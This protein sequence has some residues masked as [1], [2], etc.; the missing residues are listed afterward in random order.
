M[1]IYKILSILLFVLI[2]LD[3]TVSFIYIFSSEKI[4]KQTDC[5]DRFSNKIEGLTCTKE[6]LNYE[7]QIIT[8]MVSLFI[9]MIMFLVV[10]VNDN[11]VLE[12]F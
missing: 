1:N 3:V 2:I 5:Y 7:S 9:L 12:R 4:I 11:D 6:E 10:Y 8:C